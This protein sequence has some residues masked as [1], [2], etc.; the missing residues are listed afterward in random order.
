MKMRS[1]L[2]E[3]CWYEEWWE[4]HYPRVTCRIWIKCNRRI[5]QIDELDGKSYGKCH[6]MVWRGIWVVVIHG[7]CNL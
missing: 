7:I 4:K 5:G 2:Q 1:I 3:R 6:R